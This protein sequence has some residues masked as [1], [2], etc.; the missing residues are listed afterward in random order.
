MYKARLLQRLSKAPVANGARMRDITEDEIAARYAFVFVCQAGEL[1]IKAVLLAASLRRQLGASVELIAA[2]PEPE[3]VWGRPSAATL[4]MLARLNLR[5]VSITNPV[6]PDFPHGNK[7]ACLSVPHERPKLVLLDSDVLC[8]RSMPDDPRLHAPLSMK[9]ADEHA[10]GG[11]P[12]EWRAAFAAVGVDMPAA[13]IPMTNFGGFNLPFYNSGVIIADSSV[14]HR[15]GPLWA[16]CCAAVRDDPRVGQRRLRSDQIGLSVALQIMGTLPRS[17]DTRFNHPVHRVRLAADRLPIFAHYHW[18]EQIRQEPHLRQVTRS[19]ASHYP[20]LAEL[21]LDSAD[22]RIVL[23]DRPGERRRRGWLVRSRISAFRLRSR[24]EDATPELIISGISRSGTS[25]LCS[26]LHRYSNCVIINETPELHRSISDPIPWG[27]AR[28]YR[29]IRADVLDGRPVQNKLDRGSVTADTAVNEELGFYSP[30]VDNDRFV[31]GTKNTL[32]YLH[33]LSRIR[34]ALPEARIVAC[35][36]SPL[37][38]IGSWKTSFPHLR[39]A[40]FAIRPAGNLKDRWLPD[41]L[42]EELREIEAIQDL[43]VRRARHWHFLAQ[44]VLDS[45]HDLILVRYEEL[46][47]NPRPVLSRIFRGW[48][49]GVPR[50]PVLPS[51]IR[52]RREALTDEDLSAIFAICSQPAAEL[53]V[54]ME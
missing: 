22:W 41:P 45:L 39:E 26:L 9:P 49:A 17:L 40:N 23:R 11:A 6:S 7:I 48:D 30:A 12:D 3:R 37:D 34:R 20:E 44:R 27:L 29:Q 19:L 18:P 28:T 50:Q 15:L 1:E 43:A 51:A 5:V 46:V 16:D 31:L 32:A 53:G 47:T 10:F 25:Y 24:S 54:C 42:L 13:R 21:I 2:L 4:S 8:L 38:T 14:A 52:H 36:R 33:H 35:V